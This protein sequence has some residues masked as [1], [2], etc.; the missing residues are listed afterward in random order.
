[1]RERESVCVYVYACESGGQRGGGGGCVYACVQVSV[2][3]IVYV[4][5]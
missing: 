2:R 4:C 1:M 5:V 3:L